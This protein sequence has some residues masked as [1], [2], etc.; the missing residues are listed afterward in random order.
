MHIILGLLGVIVTILVLLNRLNQGGIDIGWLNPFSW[1]RRRK[2]RKEYELHP[3][4]TLESPLDVAALFM[5]A[6]AKINGD[7]SKEQRSVILSLF[8]SELKLDEKKAVELLSASVHIFGR[9]DDVLGNP[10]GVLIRTMD[11]FSQEQIDSV[12]FMLNKVATAEGEVSLPQQDLI[13]RI[14]KA[15]PSA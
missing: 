8:Q 7:M 4:F 15:F 2:F 12:M 14:K 6:V 5:V 9:G 13:K 3:A 11:K 10:S 1:A